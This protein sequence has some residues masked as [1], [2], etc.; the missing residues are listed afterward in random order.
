[1]FHTISA[2]SRLLVYASMIEP[3]HAAI[4]YLPSTL[5]TE[6]KK[7]QACIQ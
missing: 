1:M 6:E 4:D 2:L 5:A 3:A 7:I